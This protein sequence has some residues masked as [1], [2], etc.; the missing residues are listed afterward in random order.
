[1]LL[2]G[3]EGAIT[4]TRFSAEGFAWEGFPSLALQWFGGKSQPKN[5]VNV[6]LEVVKRGVD[7]L[8]KQ[9]EVDPSR[10]YLL[11]VSRGAE[12]ALTYATMDKRIKKVVAV[13]PSALRFQGFVDYSTPCKDSAFSWRGKPL[14]HVTID[15][16]STQSV[17]DQYNAAATST[18]NEAAWSPIEQINGPILFV[19]GDRD[20]VWASSL[21]TTAAVARLK[22]K[23]FT[24]AVQ[25]E[26]YPNAGHILLTPAGS[27]KKGAPVSTQY[28]G[29]K[30]GVTFALL[31]AWPKVNK[32]LSD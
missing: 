7:W 25:W 32:F 20:T 27:L 22:A 8:S 28:G 16:A 11:G 14:P 19:S 10:I 2:H 3:S 23:N 5:L 4:F 1:M 31:D 6:P 17:V 29:T 9:P 12:A 24:H 21:L 30:N 13:S 26:R 18:R 15:F